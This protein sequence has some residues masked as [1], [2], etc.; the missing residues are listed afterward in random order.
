MTFPTDTADLAAFIAA[1]PALTTR[2]RAVAALGLPDAW[3]GAGFI[4]N[5]LWDHLTGRTTWSDASDIDVLYFDAEALEESRDMALEGLLRDAFPDDPW[6]V[7]NQ[8]QMHLRN[9]DAPYA[10]C[11]DAL[12]HWPETATAVAAQ[13]GDA[14]TVEVLAPFGVEDLSAMIIRPTPVFAANKMDVFRQRLA[15]KRWAERWPEVT[16]VTGTAP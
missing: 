8:A 4:R 14:G 5:A 6:S 12:R 3:I 13:M 7:R 9:G 2:L 15:A 16:V 1:R 11:A 10:D